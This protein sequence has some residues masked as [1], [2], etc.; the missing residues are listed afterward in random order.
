VS[1]TADRCGKQAETA[2][3]SAY[4]VSLGGRIHADRRQLVP[5]LVPG[6]HSKQARQLPIMGN[7][8]CLTPRL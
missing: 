7:M 8:L 1:K 4:V 5:V 3:P 6:M 2:G